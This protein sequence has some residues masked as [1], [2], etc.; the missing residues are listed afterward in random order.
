MSDRF[1]ITHGDISCDILYPE[2]PAYGLTRFNH[3]GFAPDIVYKGVH[4]GQPEMVDPNRSTT[5]GAGLACEYQCEDVETSVPVGELYLK[6][7]IGYVTRLEEPWRI[8][9]FT[10]FYKPFDT[11]I[12]AQ[13]DRVL[14]VTETDMI[15]GYAYRECRM[16][17]AYE[18]TITLSV[19]FENQGEKPLKMREY[20]HNF[21][22]LG[23]LI[24][25]EKHHLALPCVEEMTLD[26]VGSHM[27]A[28]ENGVRWN[29]EKDVFFNAFEKTR[30]PEGYSWRLWH[31]DA[32]L[33]ISETDSFSPVRVAVWGL[34]HVISVEVFHRFT[35]EPGESCSWQREWRFEA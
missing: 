17:R 15:A 26:P 19:Y 32:P 31:E 13:S 3:A 33:A 28:E 8:Y 9:D 24:T 12:T 34:E 6:P 5:K 30:K 11:V 23:T 35:L 22:S 2:S 20:C 4:F 14:F 29:G 10:P 27:I 21:L 7:G 18:D 25:G 16:M 1:T